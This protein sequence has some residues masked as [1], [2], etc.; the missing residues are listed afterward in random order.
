MK[1]GRRILGEIVAVR[2]VN[3]DDA[4]NAS[5]TKVSWE[6]LTRI[7]KEITTRIPSVVKVVLDITAKPP[8]TIEW[9]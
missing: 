7:Q 3:S 9:V 2:V 1:K 8:S 6:K 4:M 5:V